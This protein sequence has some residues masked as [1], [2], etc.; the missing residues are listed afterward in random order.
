[1]PDASGDP[2]VIGTDGGDVLRA[3][4]S[5]SFVWVP[6][7]GQANTTTYSDF[8]DGD[9]RH[10]EFFD[11]PSAAAGRATFT[12]V[13]STE[14]F[15]AAPDELRF[16]FTVHPGWPHQYPDSSWSGSIEALNL[17]NNWRWDPA[18]GVLTASAQQDGDIPLTGM[19]SDHW[20]ETTSAGFAFYDVNEFWGETERGHWVL[21]PQPRNASVFG[22]A[23][24][25]TIWGGAGDQVLDGGE[26]DDRI[27]AGPGDSVLLGG[28]GHDLLRGGAGGAGGQVLDGGAGDDTIRAGDS[29][30]VLLG[31]AGDDVLR[32]GAGPQTVDGGAGRDTLLGGPGSGLL[33]GGAGADR[34]VAGA[35][36]ETLRGGSGRDVFAFGG[37]TGRDVI[38][39]FR[40]GQDA[41]EVGRGVNG[42]AVARA[43][44]LR[45]A[46]HGD[47]GGGAVL[48]L[49]GGATVTLLHVSAAALRAHLDG[50][51]R[52][53]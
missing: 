6:D 40:L 51:V 19:S 26:G 12:G 23:G 10:L 43:A 25:D 14:A 37:G 47:G 5:V 46:I 53:V 35:G 4:R 36:N 7:D 8:E 31:G 13:S 42:S 50:A 34:L 41:V 32:A 29:A 1:M 9:Y 21:D 30:Q 24:N 22:G 3:E 38:A 16:Q 28:E 15:R 44:D 52:V 45:A 11:A 49:G 2:V 20:F 33:D 48:D 17:E 27:T 18:T 39:D